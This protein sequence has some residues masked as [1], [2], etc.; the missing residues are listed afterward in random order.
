MAAEE[1]A[2]IVDEDLL[3]DDFMPFVAGKPRPPFV[4]GGRPYF[5]SL[6]SM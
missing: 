6:Q 1:V 2:D 5:P 4:A 3:E